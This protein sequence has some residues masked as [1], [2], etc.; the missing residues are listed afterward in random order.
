[1]VLEHP[2]LREGVCRLLAAQ[3]DV[4]AVDSAPDAA[5][6][7]ARAHREG[8][9][10]ALV[11]VWLSGAGGLDAIRRLRRVRPQIRIL[12]FA[13]RRPDPR[14]EEVLRA[15]ASGYLGWQAGPGELP[16]AT[17][18]LL[19]GRPYV[20]PSVE[21]D[22]SLVVCATPPAWPLARLTTREREVLR[23]IAEGLSSKEIGAQLGVSWRT[24]ESHR[25]HLMAKLG[26]R[27]LT[28]VVRVAI[29]EGVVAP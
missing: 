7:E 13:S 24:I 9:A 4:G 20:S 6:A 2:I 26:A 14:V 27:K 21:A 25:A 17:A 1:V 10:L 28:D 8:P 16:P 12:A 19:R 18:A 23:W 15:G 29:R 11:D 22:E 3:E 5:T